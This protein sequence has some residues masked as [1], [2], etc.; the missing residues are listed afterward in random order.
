MQER[1][2]GAGGTLEV[3]LV[4]ALC[5]LAVMVLAGW[6]VLGGR[7]SKA[8]RKL[9]SASR[10]MRAFDDLSSRLDALSDRVRDCEAGRVFTKM[11][12]ARLDELDKALKALREDEGSDELA[13]RLDELDRAL[14]AHKREIAMVRGIAEGAAKSAP[15]PS[16]DMGALADL[17]ARVGELDRRLAELEKRPEPPARTRTPQINESAL[18]RLVGQMVRQE[19]DEIVRDELERMVRDFFRGRR[20]PGGEG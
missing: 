13:G 3:V 1:R 10:E 5:C 19:L 16:P 9:A 8:E 18:R 17:S 2:P 14:A 4:I 6:F 20:R 15:G 11:H 12:D 7:I